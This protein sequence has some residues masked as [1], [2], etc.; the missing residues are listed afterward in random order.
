[1]SNETGTIVQVNGP[2]FNNLAAMQHARKR[3][4]SLSFS[5][6]ESQVSARSL[7]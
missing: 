7:S 5:S 2:L 4:G 3:V 1:M 6:K